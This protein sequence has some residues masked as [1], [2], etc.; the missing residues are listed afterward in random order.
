MIVAISWRD[1]NIRQQRFDLMERCY[2]NPIIIIII[3]IAII[4]GV[5][6]GCEGSARTTWVWGKNIQIS[7]F[8]GYFL[9]NFSIQHPVAP[10]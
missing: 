9:S 5:S 8:Y 10:S 3:F 6:R 4:T 1:N 2:L 7:L